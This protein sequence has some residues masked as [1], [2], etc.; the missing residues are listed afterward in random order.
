[1]PA[2]IAAVLMEQAISI[3]I[4]VELLVRS[5]PVPDS[6]VTSAFTRNQMGWMAPAHGI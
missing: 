3:E 6:G 5:R 4:A 2:S 1:M